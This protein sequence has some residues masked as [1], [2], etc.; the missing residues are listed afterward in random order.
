MRKVIPKT[1]EYM[2][3]GPVS[4]SKKKDKKIYPRLTLQHEQFPETKNWEV[5][6]KYKVTMELKMTGLSISRF[7]NDSEFEIHGF[8]S[9]DYKEKKQMAK[10]LKQS[11]ANEFVK[12]TRE[13]TMKSK[14]SDKKNIKNPTT[15]RTNY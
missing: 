7:S 8:E 2:E 13:M 15:P 10:K 3:D 5:G 11:I 9:S 14:K 12:K 1:Q 6:K 4:M